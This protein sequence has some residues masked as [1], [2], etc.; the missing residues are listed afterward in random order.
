FYGDKIME[1]PVGTNAF[2][3]AEW[4]RSSRIV[5]TRNPNFREQRYAEVAP[6]DADE[7]LKAEVAALQGRKLPL[8]DRI[9]IDIIEENQPRWL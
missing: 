4:R 7:R 9:E 1:H 3:L 6:P 2:R 8:I 5:L